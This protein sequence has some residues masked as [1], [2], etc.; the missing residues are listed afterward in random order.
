MNKNVLSVINLLSVMLFF[1]SFDQVGCIE[2]LPDILDRI[3]SHPVY[4][5]NTNEMK[6]DIEMK[7]FKCENPSLIFI[8]FQT[9]YLKRLNRQIERLLQGINVIFHEVI[10]SQVFLFQI[11]RAIF[12]LIVKYQLNIS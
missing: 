2:V 9:I 11:Y 7:L 8:I 5:F 6:I 1:S 10:I 3:T 12:I 4:F